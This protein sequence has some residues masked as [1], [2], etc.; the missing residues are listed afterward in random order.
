MLNFDK[1][2]L[3]E[4]YKAPFDSTKNQNGQVT[5]I[6]GSRLF[7]GAP[8]L[9]LTTASRIVDMVYFASP[10]TSIGGVAEKVKSDLFSFIWV[11]WEE[12]SDYIKKSDAVLIGPGLMRFRK[13]SDSSLNTPKPTDEVW[14]ET[15]EITRDFLT[16]F[17]EKKWVIDAGSLQVMDKEW[18]PENAI[19]TPNQKEY[20]ILFGD[21]KPEDASKKYKCI[22]VIKG[23]ST[24]VYSQDNV[25][26]VTGG[27]PGLTKGGTGD[28]Q[29][30]VT[31]ALLAKNESILAAPAASY[32]VKTAADKLYKKVGTAYN[33]DD[34]ANT[35]PEVFADL[36]NGK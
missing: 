8:M 13:E 29:A 35:I 22:I 28:I 16:R 3:E 19:L 31:V 20:K 24:F 17:P 9:A 14:R 27:N 10:E 4:L 15:R 21:A 23:P 1:S 18:I 7:H 5:I 25:I 11:P 6:G 32:I 30:G 12:T 34:L 26:A 2:N 33:S 36:T